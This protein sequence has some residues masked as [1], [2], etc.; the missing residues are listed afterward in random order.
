[1][2]V[3]LRE[4]RGG[5][6]IQTWN[7]YAYLAN[8]PLNATDPQGLYKQVTF[9]DFLPTFCPGIYGCGS[10]FGGSF[11]GANPV[12]ESNLFGSGG[13]DID[14]NCNFDNSAAEIEHFYGGDFSGTWNQQTMNSYEAQQFWQQ[15]PASK[16]DPA[17]YVP[18]PSEEQQKFQTS[19]WGSLPQNQ[20][21]GG[22]SAYW[23]WQYE[24]FNSYNP[25]NRT[26]VSNNPYGFPKPFAAGISDHYPFGPTKPSYS[27]SQCIQQN[28]SE[29]MACI[30]SVG[31]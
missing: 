30:E 25:D 1:M 10:S 27:L 2:H 14:P 3:S 15:Q 9:S 6:R 23:Q 20:N 16:N 5:S 21:P 18:Y 12:S 26:G 24:Q 31:R 8:N 11:W 29:I 19:L 17:V 4:S 22:Q 7:R 13:C 28:P